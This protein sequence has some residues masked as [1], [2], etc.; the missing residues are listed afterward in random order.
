MLLEDGKTYVRADGKLTQIKRTKF[1][2]FL[3]F[4]GSDKVFYTS[5]GKANRTQA[6]WKADIIAEYNPKT[7][8]DTWKT[9]R[10]IT[11]AITIAS[12]LWHLFV[13]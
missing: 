12:V 2:G 7:E 1:Y 6:N 4:Q 13:K 3:A 9:I 5:D 8:T 11:V 10:Y